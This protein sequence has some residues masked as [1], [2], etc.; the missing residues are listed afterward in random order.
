MTSLAIKS[1]KQEPS[2]PKPVVSLS[3]SPPNP[4]RVPSNS[5]QDRR[6]SPNINKNESKQNP[7]LLLQQTCNSIG[8]DLVSNQ[9]AQNN[10]AT[11]TITPNSHFMI[12]DDESAKQQHQHNNNLNSRPSLKRSP[13][14]SDDD[15]SMPSAKIHK[16]IKSY[17]NLN[18]N[19]H[20]QMPSPTSDKS[21]NYSNYTSKHQ[22]IKQHHQMQQHQQRQQE[23]LS[24]NNINY[25]D[26]NNNKTSK[27][28]NKSPINNRTSFNKSPINYP[29]NIVRSVSPQPA[30][31]TK[32]PRVSSLPPPLPPPVLTPNSNNDGFYNNIHAL[33]AN[34]PHFSVLYDQILTNMYPNQNSKVDFAATRNAALYAA[35]IIQY[36][37]NNSTKHNNNNI[38]TNS[39]KQNSTSP[40]LSSQRMNS[41]L[42]A[43]PPNTMCSNPY[44]SQCILAAA[45]TAHMNTMKKEN[46]NA[47]TIPGC[48]QCDI[49]PKKFNE[50][51]VNASSNTNMNIAHKNQNNGVH[52][53]CWLVHNNTKCGKLFSTLEELRAHVTAHTLDKEFL[54][55][56]ANQSSHLIQQQHQ[57]KSQQKHHHHHH[58]HNQ[59][60]PQICLNNSKLINSQQK[61]PSESVK[62]IDKQSE[63]MNHYHPYNGQHQLTN[64]NSSNKLSAF[65]PQQSSSSSSL[66]HQIPKQQQ[67]QQQQQLLQQQQQQNHSNSHLSYLQ[68]QQNLYQNSNSNLLLTQKLPYNSPYSSSFLNTIANQGIQNSTLHSGIQLT[69]GVPTNVSDPI[70]YPYAS[71]QYLNS[72]INPIYDIV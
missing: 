63:L 59:Q 14:S 61:H 25:I 42:T 7:L 44:C 20:P 68:A 67:L 22:L 11:V 12:N 30:N 39:L 38:S 41:H 18:N 26:Y 65:K 3:P 72:A 47:C 8:A 45:A 35:N 40:S 17:Y 2:S 70:I 53:C 15:L 33:S 57:H 64:K 43:L 24:S 23:I 27:S 52:Q 10:M 50:H 48:T 54:M 49:L 29:S 66:Q 62:T 13:T 60:H 37:N 19:N 51:I 1:T 46:D 36:N 6:T 9:S 5:L 55:V 71:H 69:G 56:A 16:D 31:S 58:H 4:P 21:I 28:P 34:N 32:I